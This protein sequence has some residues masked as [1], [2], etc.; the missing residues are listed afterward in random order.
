L[1]EGEAV[2]ARLETRTITGETVCRSGMGWIL[3]LSPLEV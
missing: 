3:D 1:F 2:G